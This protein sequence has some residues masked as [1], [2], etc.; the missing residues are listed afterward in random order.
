MCFLESFKS[1]I[2]SRLPVECNSLFQ[3]IG[4]GNNDAA[5]ISDKTSIEV[6]EPEEGLNVQYASRCRPGENRVNF[7]RVHTDPFWRDDVA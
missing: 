6:G 4:D 1:F 5:I 3:Q 2:G 7:D